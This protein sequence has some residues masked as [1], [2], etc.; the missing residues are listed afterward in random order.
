MNL[1]DTIAAISTPFGES[2]IG[3]VRVSGKDCDRIISSLFR[4]NSG[5]QSF[6]SHTLYYGELID[7]SDAEP[8]DEVLAVIMNNKKTYTREDCLEFHCHGGYLVLRKVLEAVLSLGARLAEPGEFTK[9]AFINGRIDLSQAEAVIDI[10]RA[11]T[12][13]S[14]KYAKDQL[15]GLLS[16]RIN[17]YKE[18][19]LHILA[20]IEATIDFEEEEDIELISFEK[21]IVPLNAI[22]KGLKELAGSYHYG[23]IYREGI[24]AIILGKANVGKSSIFNLLLGE[25]RAI[26]TSHPGTTRDFIEESFYADGI[27][28]RIM[29]TAGI[30][31]PGNL[32]EEM[33]QKM[34]ERGLGSADLVI[35]VMDMSQPLNQKDIE[36]IK[37]LESPK[38]ERIIV[39]NKSDLQQCFSKENIY[40]HID[41]DPVLEV[42][43]Q[44][45]IG[46]TELKDSISG[47]IV[48]GGFYQPGDTIVTN[49]RHKMALEE[50]L[51]NLHIAKS[52]ILLERYPELIA[53]DIKRA[54]DCLG[55]ITGE[56]TTEDMLDRI[57]SEFC[58]GK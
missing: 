40:E 48:N 25:E 6:K 7:A 13:R 20:E 28:I 33:G 53:F 37:S 44:Q 27:P 15:K 39:L 8:I 24:S 46:F 4:S 11:K 35:F 1:G 21:L 23:K 9:R 57:F 54:L 43:A 32:V 19:I 41:G 52:G 16:E 55:K 5:V 10:I 47:K 56:M 3:I 36:Y 18:K 30:K 29:D 42:S 26:V 58:I 2:G 49:L 14:H 51:D 17:E 38:R 31:P 50:A 34:M 22:V 45:N 12:D